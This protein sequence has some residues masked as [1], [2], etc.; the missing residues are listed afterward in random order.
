MFK[1]L[2][3]VALRNLRK[4]KWYSLINILGLTIGTTF[5]LFLIFYITDELSFDQYQKNASRIFRINSYIHERDKNTDWTY[6]QLP[7]GPQ[8][9]NFGCSDP[10]NK[11]VCVNGGRALT[12]IAI[13]RADIPGDSCNYETRSFFYGT[14]NVHDVCTLTGVSDYTVNISEVPGQLLKV[15]IANF[16]NSFSNNV[17]ATISGNHISIATQS[18]DNDGRVLTGSGTLSVNTIQMSYRL[19]VPRALTR[20]IN[21]RGL[22][23][24]SDQI[25]S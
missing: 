3:V 10:C 8:L 15:Y 13:A 22:S 1:S 21:Q 2:L 4:D 12:D 25:S 11:T 20:V 5:S 9:N 18:P 17:T 7:L 14:Y 24:T 19:Q 16:A 23:R 6:S